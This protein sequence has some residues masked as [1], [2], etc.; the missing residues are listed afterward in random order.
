MR[1][2]YYDLRDIADQAQLISQ[3]DSF[4]GDQM[5]R[6]YHL[7]MLLKQTDEDFSKDADYLTGEN[8]SAFGIWFSQQSSE[9]DALCDA[10]PVDPEKIREFMR[11]LQTNAEKLYQPFTAEDGRNFDKTIRVKEFTAVISDVHDQ[12]L[13]P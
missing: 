4:N 7:R 2:I 9:I 10:E 1:T 6:L 11:N 13:A 3:M 12:L 8:P 5:L